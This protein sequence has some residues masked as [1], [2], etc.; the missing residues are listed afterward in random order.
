[1]PLECDDWQPLID[2]LAEDLVF[3]AT[4]PD[5]RPISGELR[6]KQAV[7]EHLIDLGNLL[8][9]RPDH[10]SRPPKHLGQAT[11]SDPGSRSATRC[12]RGSARTAA[13]PR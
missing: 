4:I 12:N 9:F 3:T 11:L 1:M 5:G 13:R 10:P 2:H 7:V 8:V 6:G